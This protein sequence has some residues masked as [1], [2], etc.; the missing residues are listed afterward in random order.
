METTTIHDAMQKCTTK[1]EKKQFLKTISIQAKEAIELA[2]TEETTVNNVLISWLTNETHQEFNNFWEWKKKG[3]SVK[4]GE[5]AFFVW[6]KKRT[7]TDKNQDNDTDEKK[8]SFFSLAYLFSN[9]QVEPSKNKEN[10]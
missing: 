4:K 6:S 9:A 2:T 3:F 1:E 8:Y 7:A 5:K 10:A